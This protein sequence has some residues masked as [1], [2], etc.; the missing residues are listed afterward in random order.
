MWGAVL[1]RNWARVRSHAK[2]VLGR[3]AGEALERNPWARCF[4]KHNPRNQRQ[5][6]LGTIFAATVGLGKKHRDPEHHTALFVWFF[7][8]RTDVLRGPNLFVTSLKGPKP[9]KYKG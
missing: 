3:V 2:R 8:V 1:Q 7:F 6:F 9:T 5:N 4:G